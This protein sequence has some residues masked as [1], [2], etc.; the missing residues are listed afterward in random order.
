[1]DIEVAATLDRM[2]KHKLKDDELE[3]FTAEQVQ[4]M[5]DFCA[6]KHAAFEKLY[7]QA[8]DISL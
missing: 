7:N 5:R 2:Y 3:R 8:L 4:Q 6:K 1:M